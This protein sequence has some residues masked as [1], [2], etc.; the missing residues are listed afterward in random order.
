VAVNHNNETIG[1]NNVAAGNYDIAIIPGVTPAAVCVII[2]QGSSATGSDSDLVTS[3]TYGIAAGAVTLTRLRADTK[4]TGEA[5][6]AYVYWAAGVLP[7]GNQTL[8]VVR[9]GTVSMAACVNTMTVTVPASF[10]VAADA[11]NGFTSDSQLNPSWALATSASVNTVCYQGMFSGLAT[12]PT[13]PATGWAQQGMVDPGQWGYVWARRTAAG[14][15]VACGWT[16][17]ADDVVGASAA[18]KE[19][20]IPPAATQAPAPRRQLQ[21]VKDSCW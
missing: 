3:V 2:C 13:T 5:G 17:S 7:A 6:R 19:V 4:A 16:A 10:T 12:L 8:R 11:D 9:T 21:A 15:S 18:F 1:A 20:A 14:G